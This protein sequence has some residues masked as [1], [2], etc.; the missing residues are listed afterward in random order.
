MSAGSGVTRGWRTPDLL[1][2]LAGHALLVGIAALLGASHAVKDTRRPIVFNVSVVSAGTPL[3]EAAEAKSATLVEARPK[4]QAKPKAKVEAK[5]KTEGKAAPKKGDGMVR[6]KGLG[7]GARIEGAEALGYSYYLN[8]ILTRIS[9]NWINPYAGS[10][11]TFNSTIMF[12]IERDG[13]VKDVK[14]EKKSGDAAYDAS[15]ER[16]LLVLDRLPPLPPEFTGPRLK[17]HLEFEQK[18]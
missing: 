3:P 1:L 17:L 4:S 13:T 7:L 11:R 14:I 15:C 16:A 10:G 12:V 9:D 8:V 18:P 6:R 5:A 2:S